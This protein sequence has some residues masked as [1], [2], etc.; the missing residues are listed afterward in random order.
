MDLTLKT[1]VGRNKEQE[2]L[3]KL[4]EKTIRGEGC[5]C[6][7]SGESGSGKTGLVEAVLSQNQDSVRHLTG[8]A[9]PE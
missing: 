2:Q 7:I 5:V 1:L 6:L 9:L 8:R 4:I 3:Q